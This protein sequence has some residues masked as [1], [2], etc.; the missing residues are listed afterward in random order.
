MKTAPN[1]IK[2]LNSTHSLLSNWSGLKTCS[3]IVLISTMVMAGCASSPKKPDGAEELRNKLSQLQNDPNLA[4]LAPVALNE[5]EAAV[6]AAEQPTKDKDLAAH[7]LWIAESRVEIA[8]A[9]AQSRYNEDQRAALSEG[10]E[11]ARL[12]SRTQEADSARQAAERARQDAESARRE[13]E[14]LK[15]QMADMNARPTD[16]GLVMTLGDVLF[17]T[18]KAELMGGAASNLDKLANFLKEYPQRTA[19]IEGHTDNVGSADLNRG[20]SQ[21]RADSVKS[22]L[23]QRGVESNR[24]ST[25]GKGFDAPVASNDTAAGRQQNRRV[26]III[27]E[28]NANSSL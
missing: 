28:S 16:R 9:R 4:S 21:R 25:T 26:E 7:R 23:V 11:A 3:G 20:L 19:E 8:R 10:R 15:Q 12:N 1:K 2:N 14:E 5:A 6:K 24:L 13:A 17:A 27:S 22:Y 18:G